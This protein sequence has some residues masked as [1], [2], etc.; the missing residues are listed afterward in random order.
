M[1]EKNTTIQIKDQT[2]KRLVYVRDL[3]S[4]PDYNTVIN[5]LL[6]Q[7]GYPTWQ[8]AESLGLKSITKKAKTQK[9][10]VPA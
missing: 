10:E 3:L 4:K 8:E 2:R 1:S 9:A 6:D 5:L 7:G